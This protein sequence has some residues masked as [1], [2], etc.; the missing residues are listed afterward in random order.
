MRVF[1]ALPQGRG[2]ISSYGVKFLRFS[3]LNLQKFALSEF[4]FVHGCC[5]FFKLFGA[6]GKP[7]G[8]ALY[9][10]VHNESAE[11]QSSVQPD[12]GVG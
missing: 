8:G 7:L 10:A 1:P 9:D 3:S 12:L 11:D 6:L 2:K 5:R 4:Y